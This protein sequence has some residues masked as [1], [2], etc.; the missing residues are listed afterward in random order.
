MDLNCIIYKCVKDEGTFLKEFISA[1]QFSFFFNKKN[2][3]FK[4]LKKFGP[5]YLMLS[6][7]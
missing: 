3:Y 2:K 1:K 4:D 6:M 5:Q 7:N